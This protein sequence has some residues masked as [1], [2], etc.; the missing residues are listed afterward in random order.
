MA[1]CSYCNSTIIFGG[2][3]QGAYTFCNKGCQQKGVLLAIADK[4]PESSVTSLTA[5]VHQGLC[6][7]CGGSGPV[8]LH[9]SH[10]VWSA[11]VLTSWSSRP[12]LSCRPCGVRRQIGDT[13]LSLVAGWWGFPWGLIMTPVQVVRNFVALFKSPDPMKASPQMERILRLQLAGQ[14]ASRSEATR[15]A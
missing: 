14:V 8:D 3:S 13:L 4:L 2:V 1:A 11:L 6:P 15:P 7:V 10:R 9:T 12:R 5:Q